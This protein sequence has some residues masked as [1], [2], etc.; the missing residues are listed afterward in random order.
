M[1]LFVAIT[2]PAA[3][4]DELEARV[5]P[6]RSAWPDLRWTSQGAWHVTLAFFGEV[7]DAT[8]LALGP[9]LER[10]ARKKPC[11]RMSVAGSGAFPAR[12]MAQ[13]LWT[14]IQ[15]EQAL[16]QLSDSVKAAGRRAGTPMP[17]RRRRRHYQPHLTLARCRAPLDVSSLVAALAGY[18]GTEWTASEI[19]L[20][21]SRLDSEPRYEVMG[22]WPLGK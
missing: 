12:S 4:L 8:A 3:V 18:A 14:G 6:L 5:A 21:R 20:I 9:R 13:V 11:L 17:D 10:A 2:P 19:Q 15:A 1:R 16:S 22:A 7:S